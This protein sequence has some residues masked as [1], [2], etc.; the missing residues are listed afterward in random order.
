MHRRPGVAK[1]PIPRGKQ[2]EVFERISWDEALDAITARLTDISTKFGPEAILPYSYAGNM[3]VLGYG[4]MD[5]RF[6]RG[7][8]PR[9]L[10]GPFALLPVARR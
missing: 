6:F 4:S 7:W 2:A 10:I 5:R 3:A 1:G 8:E 9:D